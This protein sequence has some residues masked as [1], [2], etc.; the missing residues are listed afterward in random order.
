MRYHPFS[1]TVWQCILYIALPLLSFVLALFWAFWS[2]DTFKQYAES[3]I[4]LIEFSHI[5]VAI[6]G[7][8]FSLQLC[9]LFVKK[10]NGWGVCLSVFASL[11]CLYI[12]GE[13]ASY[14]QHFFEWQVDEFF[15][16]IN[17]QRES[18]LHNISSWFD[19]KP[20]AVLEIAIVLGG[21]LLPLFPAVMLKIVPTGLRAYAP[22]LL[23][24]Q[25]A[26]LLC[27]P[28]YQNA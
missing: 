24:F 11:V 26:C 3:E 18:N 20:R 7:F 5:I 4:G 21:L 1:I 12:A 10:E 15:L 28:D 23:F 17:D 22:T 8:V 2:P 6:I 9:L 14:G 16:E 19:Q 13:E 27:C 25:P